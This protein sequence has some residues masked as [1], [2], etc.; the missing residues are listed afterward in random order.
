MD[1]AG[2]GIE[3]QERVYCIAEVQERVRMLQKRV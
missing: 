1:A 2:E 3:L